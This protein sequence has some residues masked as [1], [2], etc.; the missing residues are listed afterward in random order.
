MDRYLT[1]PDRALT[2]RLNQNMRDLLAMQSKNL[3][4]GAVREAFAA[5]PISVASGGSPTT[6]VTLDLD[7]GDW[8]VFL[9]ATATTNLSSSGNVNMTMGSTFEITG[10]LGDDVAFQNRTGSRTVQL[11]TVV[12]VSLSDITPCPLLFSW[13][14]PGPNIQCRSATIAIAPA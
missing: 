4:S 9:S 14:G 7:P 1:L 13:T 5:G 11:S 2:D 10:L 8:V 3:G 12:F 6:L